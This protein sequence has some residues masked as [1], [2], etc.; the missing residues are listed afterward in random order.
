MDI[1]DQALSNNYEDFRSVYSDG[2]FTVEDFLLE[3]NDRLR[4]PISKQVLY[5]HLRGLNQKPVTYGL[6]DIAALYIVTAWIRRPGSKG[7]HT[8]IEFMEK[9]GKELQSAIDGD[10]PGAIARWHQAKTI[11]VR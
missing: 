2:L 3:V 11:A 5:N 7:I 9:I 10:R 1:I 6:Y 4:T 8:K